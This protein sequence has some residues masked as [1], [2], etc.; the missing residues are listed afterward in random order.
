MKINIQARHV[1]DKMETQTQLHKKP[2]SIMLQTPS[3][4]E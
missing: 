1:Y 2:Y 4:E 3:D